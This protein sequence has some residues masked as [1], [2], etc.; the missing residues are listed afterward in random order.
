MAFV[1]F[2]CVTERAQREDVG[3]GS[4]SC[5]GR[6]QPETGGVR[7]D[8]SNPFTG[9]GPAT[10][11]NIWN[12]KSDTCQ[13]VQGWKGCV[14][15]LGSELL[16]RVLRSFT[17]FDVALILHL[18]TGMCACTPNNSYRHSKHTTN[19]SMTQQLQKYSINENEI[20]GFCE[21]LWVHIRPT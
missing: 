1:V 8:L 5:P 18:M 12:N 11:N 20:I 17:S 14:I 2:P 7:P 15:K 6:G 16:C 10:N 21:C 19:I 13:T 9:K 4:Q 3:P